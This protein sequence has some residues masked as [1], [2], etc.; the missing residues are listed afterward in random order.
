M[1]K[2]WPKAWNFGTA[3]YPPAVYSDFIAK[4]NQGYFILYSLNECTFKL[5]HMN[6][7]LLT[8]TYLR[9]FLQTV[10]VKRGTGTFWYFKL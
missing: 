1:A 6:E 5:L 3:E 7:A 10:L 2:D 4:S 9:P 8:A